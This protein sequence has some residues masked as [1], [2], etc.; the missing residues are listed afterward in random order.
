MWLTAK[1][2]GERLGVADRTVRE[3]FLPLADFPRPFRAH[4]TARMK[5]DA[6]EIDQWWASR[7]V[8]AAR[9]CPPRTPYSKSPNSSGRGGRQSAR[10]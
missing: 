5:W 9:Q 8:K 3:L 4:P 1:Q 7:Q 6:A 2:V 10:G